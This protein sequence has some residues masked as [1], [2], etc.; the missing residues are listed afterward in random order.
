MDSAV[1]ERQMFPRQTKQILT[2]LHSRILDLLPRYNPNVSAC[3]SFGRKC[4]RRR[5]LSGRM[6]LWWCLLQDS[7]PQGFGVNEHGVAKNEENL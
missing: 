2:I 7:D 4:I 1:G 5:H 3:L 6:T